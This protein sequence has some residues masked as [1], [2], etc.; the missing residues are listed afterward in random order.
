MKF[1]TAINCIDGRTQTPVIEFMKKKFGVDFIDMIT[2]PGPNK[3]LAEDKNSFLIETIKNG[4]EIS[5]NKHYSALVAVVGHYD[6][7]ANPTDKENHIE[8]I[9]KA[10]KKVESW[11]LNVQ[12]IGL[13]I[14]ANWEVHQVV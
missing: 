3:L 1:A 14:D 10:I 5:V 4:V 13:W 11:N 2:T 8:Q 6:C 12:I 7:A 9:L